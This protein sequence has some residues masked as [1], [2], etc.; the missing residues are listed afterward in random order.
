MH[1]QDV[2]LSRNA[3]VH[4]IHRSARSKA[5][6]A[7]PAGG[8]P[9]VGVNLRHADGSCED[10]V[11]IWWGG[12]RLFPARPVCGKV[13]GCTSLD[14]ACCEYTLV[15]DPLRRADANEQVE[16]SALGFCEAALSDGRLLTSLARSTAV[17]DAFVAA[18][19]QQPQLERRLTAALQAT[20]IRVWNAT[21]HSSKVWSSSFVNGRHDGS[22]SW[23]STEVADAL[24]DMFALAR[25]TPSWATPPPR[26][27]AACVTF[28]PHAASNSKP[29]W[30]VCRHT[31]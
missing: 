1:S 18:D 14:H 10:R 27:R 17:Q 22:D 25:L 5:G 21:R 2:S 12:K 29:P 8:H 24:V 23:T 28:A 11:S 3:Y 4:R 13:A 15:P 30:L 19:G 26:S 31:T 7:S 9:F 16:R 6:R 20:G